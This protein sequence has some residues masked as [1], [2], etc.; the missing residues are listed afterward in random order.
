MIKLIPIL[1]Q[2]IQE[3]GNH[4][5]DTEYKTET[6]SRVNVEPTIKLF[7]KEMGTIF[8]EKQTSF[9]DELLD[10]SN[11]LGST[12]GEGNPGD[13]DL[14]YS[15]KHFFIENDSNR[16]PDLAGWEIKEE[17]FNPRYEEN[18]SNSQT[19]K[20]LN[21]KDSNDETVK[22]DKQVVEAQQQLRTMI[23][24]IV[25]KINSKGGLLQASN[26]AALGGTIHFSLPQ[27]NGKENLDIRAQVDLDI[28][29]MEW[30]K[31]RYNSELPED[32]PKIK[33][34]HRG[35]LMLALFAVTGYTFK[36]GKGFISK[37][38]DKVIGKT[39][40]DAIDVFNKEYEP[41]QNLTLDVVNSW[42]KLLNYVNTSLKPGD[43]E[44]TLDMFTKAISRVTNGYMP[45]L[46]TKDNNI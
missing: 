28:G 31:F 44:K 38:T 42:T 25:N 20:K 19:Y 21:K 6:I 45:D 37:E 35:Q 27:S 8:T 12:K 34:Y 32:D 3:G 26:K 2:I 43:K 13:L 16:Q 41:I 23:D 30:L 36:S 33:G 22:A 11:W 5:D 1:K 7:V 39:P 10:S 40:Q 4:F 17:D 9:N 14:A 46:S 15:V 29:D 18:L 24:L